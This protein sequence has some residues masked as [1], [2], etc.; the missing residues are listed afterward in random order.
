MSDR[1]ADTLPTV[2]P[3]QRR[4]SNIFSGWT[5]SRRAISVEPSKAS[6]KWSQV[7]QRNSSLVPFLET[8]SIRR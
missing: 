7:K 2:R 5:V 8:N 6:S 1:S 3:G 4:Y